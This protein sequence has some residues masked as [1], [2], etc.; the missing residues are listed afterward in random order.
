MAVSPANEII[1]RVW[2]GNKD[3]AH[4]ADFLKAKGFTVI[5]NCTKDIE[6]IPLREGAWHGKHY[7]VPIDDN[8]HPAEIANL[9]TWS[10]EIV[11]NMMRE[12]NRGQTI[13]VHC[14]AGRQRS[15]ACVAMFLIALG[16]MTTDQAI[17]K[18]RMH[19]NAAF[20]PL[21]NFEAAIRH[22]EK[23]LFEHIS[24]NAKV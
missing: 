21:V 5:F 17:A 14:Y 1:P 2:I 8:R 23:N 12:Y 10:P 16:R 7:R 4:D 18:V 3:A 24:N 9:A 15:A 20:F 13:L 6:P 22:F 11:Y 19:R